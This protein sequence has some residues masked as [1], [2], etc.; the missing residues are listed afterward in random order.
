MNKKPFGLGTITILQDFVSK[1]V[2]FLPVH[3]QHNLGKYLA[4]KKAHYL[5]ALSGIEGDYLDF[6]VFS[7]SSLAHSIRAYNSIS[8]VDNRKYNT[9]FYGFDSFKGFDESEKKYSDHPFFKNENFVWSYEKVNKRISKLE[10]KY[11][12]ESHI[13]EGFFKDTLI[14]KNFSI[15][16]ASIVLL[17]VDLYMATKEA[18]NFLTPY[19]Q[20]G[21][22]ILVDEYGVPFQSK[23]SPKS[24]L[25]EWE[26][27]NNFNL[28]YTASYGMGGAVYIVN[29][30]Y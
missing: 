27:E 9:Q 22:I 24:A 2:G 10:K 18:L 26:K 5:T 29:N 8:A 17:D 7:G 16:K 4:L 19:V 23:N 15:D 13:V 12:V 28:S 3:L 21:M 6:G 20:S 11:S 1:T 30:T 14:N 25:S